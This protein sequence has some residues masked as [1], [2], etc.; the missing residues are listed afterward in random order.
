MF[1]QRV[2]VASSG[3]IIGCLGRTRRQRGVRPRHDREW[4]QESPLH[5]SDSVAQRR[6]RQSWNVS[7]WHGASWV[8]AGFR[9]RTRIDLTDIAAWPI[10]GR[11]HGQALRQAQLATTFKIAA[12]AVG[13]ATA[14]RGP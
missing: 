3:R 9:D 5:Q 7:L 12:T 14:T 6:Q 11:V 2:P 13:E 8:Q 4:S 10:V 1:H